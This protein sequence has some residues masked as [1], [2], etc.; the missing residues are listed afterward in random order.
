[1]HNRVQQQQE[2][3]SDVHTFLILD[4]IFMLEY[5]KATSE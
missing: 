2:R 1:M 3:N 4:M 5:S